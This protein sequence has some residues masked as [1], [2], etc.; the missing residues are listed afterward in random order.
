MESNRPS[1]GSENVNVGLQTWC[2]IMVYKYVSGCLV[3][4]L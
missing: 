2:F 3:S 4:L 1:G